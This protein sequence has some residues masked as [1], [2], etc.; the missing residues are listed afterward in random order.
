MSSAGPGRDNCRGN[1]SLYE[2]H[3][4]SYVYIAFLVNNIDPYIVSMSSQ[5]K[6]KRPVADL[7]VGDSDIFY[8]VRELRVMKLNLRLFGREGQSQTGLQQIKDGGASPGLWRAGH[9][10]GRRPL[11][12]EFTETAE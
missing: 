8:V 11:S 7:H 4:Y 3:D 1:D 9:R 6:I 12:R 10:V 5:G 2:L